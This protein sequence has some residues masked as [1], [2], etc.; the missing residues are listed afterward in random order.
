M[1]LIINGHLE[2]NQKEKNEN[3]Y[4]YNCNDWDN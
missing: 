2:K 4:S 3:S 1:D